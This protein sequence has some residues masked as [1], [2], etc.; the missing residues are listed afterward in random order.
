MDPGGEA[1]PR[2]PTPSFI[3]IHIVAQNLNNDSTA[4]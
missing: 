1:A 3:I 4:S 2:K